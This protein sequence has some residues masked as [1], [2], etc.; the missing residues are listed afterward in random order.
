MPR[1]AVRDRDTGRAGFPA[2]GTT[3]VVVVTD[4]RRI[5]AA[6]RGLRAELAAIEVTCSRFRADSE[7]SRLHNATGATVALSGLL[8]DALATAL[9]AARL[10]GGLVDPTVGTAVA[11]LGYDRDFTEIDPAGPAPAEP[12]RPVPGWWRVLLDHPGRQVVLPREVRLDLGATAK[13][14]AADRAAGRLAADLGCGV[15][16]SLGG[17]V[18]VAGPPPAG[19]WRLG[20]GDDHR[21]APDTSV[22]IATGGLATSSTTCRSWRR[23]GR[24]VHHI[25]DP[26]TGDIPEPVWRTVS[27]AAASCVDANTASTAAIVLGA[28]APAW[29]TAWKLPARLVGMSGQVHTVAGWPA[30]PEPAPVAGVRS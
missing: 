9:R 22:V 14:F 4:P 1:P 5:G 10:T 26:R 25:V 28:A 18:A 7:I 2:L 24:L 29:L 15:L 3:A 27:V 30:E 11:N 23:A 21:T 16:V 12:P 8:A 17:D 20:V 19:G 13:A 6:E